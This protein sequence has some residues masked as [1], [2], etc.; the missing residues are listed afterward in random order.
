[1]LLKAR[2]RQLVP[3]SNKC[4]EIQCL[5][6]LFFFLVILKER[7]IYN[8]CSNKDWRRYFFFFLIQQ[9]SWWT[10]PSKVANKK[11]IVRKWA[12]ELYMQNCVIFLDWIRFQYKFCVKARNSDNY[13]ILYKSGLLYNYWYYLN[14]CECKCK[15]IWVI[16][17][18]KGL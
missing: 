3:L 1:M 11:K 7:T 14:I 16:L 12:I 8:H 13:R 15:R 4:R 18:K 2:S 5:C 10:S 17:K 9:R 6:P